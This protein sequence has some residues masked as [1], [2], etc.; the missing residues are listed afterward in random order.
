[1]AHYVG[2][3]RTLLGG[4]IPPL[5]APE[6]VLGA[7]IL[8]NG[9]FETAGAGGADIWANWAENAGTGALADETT[10]VQAGG[11]AA[12]IT[13]APV[14]GAPVIEQ[15]ATVAANAWHILQFYARG[16]GTNAG[17]WQI[18]EVTGATNITT[19]ASTAVTATT[20]AQ[21][22]AVW[23]MVPVNTTVRIR[24]LAGNAGTGAVSYF[25]T[26]SV[27]A[28]A[29]ASM[30]SARAYSTHATTK[31]A[32]TVVSGTRA[33]V[34]CNLDSVASPANFVVASH[35]GTTARLTKC[36][37]GTYTELIATTTAYSAGAF[38]EVRRTA[39]TND[40]EL[41]YAGSKV[42]TTQTV[43]DAGITGNVL[44]GY[45]NTYASNTVA[46]FSCLPS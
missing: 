37:A 41:Y 3:R 30:F 5:A 4:G 28:I 17:R 16:D 38:V 22:S 1:M 7:E 11:H 14:S 39:G 31:A 24:A 23:R 43:A 34:V 32:C 46:S 6:P 42:G 15:D 25:D 12:K 19:L 26:F 40:Y 45:F 33:G 2:A 18:Y 13:A 35:D 10:I 8:V 29:L 20:Y 27:K 9:G 36:V 44:H 21:K